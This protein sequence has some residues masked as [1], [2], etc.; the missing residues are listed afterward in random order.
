MR[1]TV[2]SFLLVAL[3][4]IHTHAEEATNAGSVVK[5][6]EE[7]NLAEIQG[8]RP[9]S[10]EGFSLKERNE[11]ALAAAKSLSIKEYIGAIGTDSIYRHFTK[12]HKQDSPQ[13][14]ECRRQLGI[15]W[16]A[17]SLLQ[18]LAEERMIDDPKVVPY[19]IDALDH[20]DRYRVGQKCFY[21]LTALTR[22][23]SGDIYWAR[24]VPDA[25]QHA[26]ICRWWKDWWKQNKEKHPIFD[27]ELE[28]LARKR[29]LQLTRIVAENLRPRFP[30]L[31]L[32][33]VPE[34]LP[35][36]WQRPLFYV[37]YDPSTWSLPLDFFNGITRKRLP[38]ILVSCRFQS[39]GLQ[40]TWAIEEKL[41][42][43]GKLRD[44]MKT[45][46][47]E[48]LQ[49]SDLLV[50]VMVASENETLMKAMDSAFGQTP[51]A[52]PTGAHDGLPVAPDR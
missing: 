15:N 44:R 21:A 5:A 10:S 37:E 8:I 18:H 41:Q 48:T 42:P 7:R 51:T 20:P 33:Q 45:C 39:A 47:S 14:A 1:I 30:E 36:R 27:A 6:F 31:N 9:R 34:T 22:Q 23:E 29:V 2:T 35:L 50:E 49:G 24:L 28:T 17:A 25:K 32:F 16:S 52:Q 4:P 11:V 46:Y 38:W 40:D 3:L 19:L 43:T 26:E 13:E 12:P